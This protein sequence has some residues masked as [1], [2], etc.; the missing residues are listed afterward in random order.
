ME[1]DPWQVAHLR[2]LYQ[3]GVGPLS[4]AA[5]EVMGEPITAVQRAFALPDP[6]QVSD[7]Q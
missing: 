6:G 2:Y 1:V 5:I 4:E 3:A 7:A